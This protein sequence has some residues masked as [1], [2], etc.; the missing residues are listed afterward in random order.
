MGYF[1]CKCDICIVVSEL[2]EQNESLDTFHTYSE[3][4]Y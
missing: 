3:V 2:F 1:S 4:F